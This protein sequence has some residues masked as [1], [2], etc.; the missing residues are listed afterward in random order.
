MVS[1]QQC[2]RLVGKWVQFRTPHGV[3]RGI[4]ERVTHGEVV[5]IA[6]KAY[7][8]ADLAIDLRP[9]ERERLDIALAWGGYG[10]GGAGGYPGG[11]YGYGARGYGGGYGWGWGRWAVSFLIIYVLF[12]LFWW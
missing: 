9:D 6:P 10:G 7:L 3:H 11:G 8:P 12:G 2:E 5:V 4:V 1:K